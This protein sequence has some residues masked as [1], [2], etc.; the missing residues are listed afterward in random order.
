[1]PRGYAGRRKS[2]KVTTMGRTEIRCAL[3]I[4]SL[5]TACAPGMS[6]PQAS[7]T[8]SGLH[9]SPIAPPL[10]VQRCP[11]IVAPYA[12][13]TL[14]S[15][16]LVFLTGDLFGAADVYITQGSLEAARLVCQS[17]SAQDRC[18]VSP[19]GTRVLTVEMEDEMVVGFQVI[20][21]FGG[22]T[23][24]QPWRETWPSLE[25]PNFLHWWDEERV[26]YMSEARTQVVLWTDTGEVW[27]EIP[28]DEGV[29]GWSPDAELVVYADGQR[30]A[31]IRDVGTAEDVAELAT[32]ATRRT[33]LATWTHDGER[34]AYASGGFDSPEEIFVYDRRGRGGQV[35]EFSSDFSFF[36]LLWMDWSHDGG[37]LALWANA[38]AVGDGPSGTPGE[39]RFYVCD[40]ASGMLTNYCRSW[41]PAETRGL[42]RVG[43][44]YSMWSPDD[45]Q[46]LVVAD[47]LEPSVIVDVENGMTHNLPQGVLGL[48]LVP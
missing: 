32:G 36:G 4:A 8:T 3:A 27:V 39:I 48:R 41:R 9:G 19:G 18:A 12:A 43:L 31:A 26:Y 7:P 11:S 5:L 44:H 2:H 34:L 1:M 13:D 24:Q 10:V 40:V 37:R 33:R 38:R 15:G 35:S 17:A 6:V 45:S 14:H 16:S 29:V 23:V 22:E 46:L 21:T 25:R 20:P 42:D 30:P 47:A 28:W